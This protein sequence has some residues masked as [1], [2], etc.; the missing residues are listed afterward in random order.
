MSDIKVGDK[1]RITAAYEEIGGP[2]HVGVEFEVTNVI[3]YP[4]RTT[5]RVLH[6]YVIT[7]DP[8]GWGVWANYLEKVEPVPP[9]KSRGEVEAEIAALTEQLPMYSG[10]SA[11]LYRTAQDTISTL[12]WVLS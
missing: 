10:M 1:V 4:W 9:M 7:G 12:R 6:E 8:M 11:A 5:D 3:H 2:E